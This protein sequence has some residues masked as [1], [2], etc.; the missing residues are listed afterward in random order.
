MAYIK[1]ICERAR[2]TERASHI[3]I[4]T[5]T[6]PEPDADDLKGCYD[7][8]T[9]EAWSQAVAYHLTPIMYKTESITIYTY[10]PRM[11]LT[12][13]QD[14]HAEVAQRL[15]NITCYT[16]FPSTD[17][18]DYLAPVQTELL[19]LVSV[20]G[21]SPIRLA[22]LQHV[23]TLRIYSLGIQLTWDEIKTTLRSC[24][25][26]EELEVADVAFEV[27][28]NTG[29]V[30]IPTLRILK[31]DI[32]EM[33]GMEILELISTPGL[34]EFCVQ[35]DFDAPWDRVVLHMRPILRSIKRCSIGTGIYTDE[36]KDFMSELHSV[37]VL[38]IRRGGS[39]FTENMTRS[40]APGHPTMKSLKR[41]IVARGLSQEQA[42]R[43]RA[44]PGANV[45]V[46]YEGRQDEDEESFVQWD[47]DCERL[48]GA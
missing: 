27:E 31:V 36:L 35:G 2:S 32:T 14:H 34:V 23:K 1:S 9:I 11:I 47:F 42:L 3:H 18:T 44:W 26:L 12:I 20:S 46:I 41:W 28:S 22:H 19:E 7:V 25:V 15:K 21:V 38:D 5:E 6:E 17:A 33:G 29:S 10:N 40:F 45:E 37:E 24:V 16:T 8:R 48:G 43:L 13:L 39:Q 4:S 30:E